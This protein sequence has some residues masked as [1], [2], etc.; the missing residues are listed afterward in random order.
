[1]KDDGRAAL[2]IGADKVAGGIS[3]DDRIFFNWLYSNYNVTGH[4]GAD[5]KLYNK[6]G[7][8]WPV[9]IISISGRLKSERI[10]PQEGVI[11]RYDNWSELYSNQGKYWIPKTTGQPSLMMVLNQTGQKMTP[12]L[13]K[14]LMLRK[15]ERLIQ[16]AGRRRAKQAL[17]MSLE[18]SPEMY[19]ISQMVNP[20]DWPQAIMNSDQMQEQLKKINWKANASVL[21]I[22][23]AKET[24]QSQTIESLLESL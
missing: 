22:L 13:H 14:S 17:E 18:A 24:Y 15:L 3:T 23:G 16:Q 11:Q 21:E 9:R 2:I 10:G 1:M 5:G 6:Q 19:Q 20:T 7:A 12:Q 8:G 4:I